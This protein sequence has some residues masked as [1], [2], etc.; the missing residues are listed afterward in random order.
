MISRQVEAVRAALEQ[1]GI[2][3]LNGDAPGVR[4]HAKGASKRK[5]RTRTQV[6][7]LFAAKKRA[8]GVAAPGEF[9]DQFQREEQG[10]T[11]LVGYPTIALDLGRFNLERWT[12]RPEEEAPP[13]ADG[14]LRVAAKATLLRSDIPANGGAW[15]D[16]KGQMCGRMELQMRYCRAAGCL[17]VA[18]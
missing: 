11:N 18:P 9:S 5:R 17:S 13:F 16:G 6:G 3:F 2:E 4:L 1:A 8:Q 14:A 7:R 15:G 12:T 10:G